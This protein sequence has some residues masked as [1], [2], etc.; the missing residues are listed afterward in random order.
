MRRA[1]LSL[2]LVLLLPAGCFRPRQ[3]DPEAEPP[4][5]EVHNRFFGAVVIYVLSAGNDVRLGMVQSNRAETFDFPMG[6]NPYSSSI[7]LRVDP[8]GDDRGYISPG[9]A[10]SSGTTIVLTVENELRHSSVIVR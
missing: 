1:L 5:I 8:I 4:R 7:R 3:R 6:V 10:A 9:I 2:L